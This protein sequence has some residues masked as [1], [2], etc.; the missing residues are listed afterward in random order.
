MDFC[1]DD[2][3]KDCVSQTNVS[4]IL[5]MRETTPMMSVNILF[6]QKSESEKRIEV[7]QLGSKSNT[8]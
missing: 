8:T 2:E 1:F 7:A 6:T 3:K 5:N 4:K